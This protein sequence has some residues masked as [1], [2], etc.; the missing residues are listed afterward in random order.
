MIK[1]VP[2][3]GSRPEDYDVYWQGKRIGYLRLRHGHFRAICPDV[4]GDLVY[5]VYVDDELGLFPSE[6]DVG[7]DLV[8]HVYVGDE[9][10]GE[11]RDHYINEA[12]KAI[13]RKQGLPEDNYEIEDGTV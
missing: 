5:H 8:Y 3:C 6:L 11:L 7:G 13:C 9:L 2:L 10:G 1:I 12:L 4:D